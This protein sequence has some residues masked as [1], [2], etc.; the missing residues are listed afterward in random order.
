MKNKMIKHGIAII[1]IAIL[2]S[3]SVTNC[4]LLALAAQ[5]RENKEQARQVEETRRAE[6]ARQTE[7]IRQERLAQSQAQELSFGIEVSGY[8]GAGEAYWFKVQAVGDGQMSVRTSGNTSTYLEAYDSINNKITDS[9]RFASMDNNAGLSIF[10]EAGKNYFIRLR[11]GSSSISGQGPYSIIAILRQAQDLSSGT[12]VSGNL[13]ARETHWF[14]VQAT[15]NGVMVVYTS[16]NTDTFLRAYGSDAMEITSNN[17][18]GEGR[19]ARLRFPVIAGRTYF[20]ELF[21]TGGSS[22]TGGSY[23]IIALD[24]AIAADT[25]RSEEEAARRRLEEANRYDPSKFTLVPSNFR[26]ADYTARDLFNV[27][28]WVES[29]DFSTALPRVGNRQPFV[30]DVVFVRQDGTDI[31]FKTNDNAITQSMKINSRSGLTAGQS[32]R[33]YYMVT[34][35]QYRLAVW[36]V[37]AIERL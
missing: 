25:L 24:E 34:K 36:Q 1:G 26:P 6:E 28:A 15:G 18:G 20:I 19:N 13:G 33:L 37:I 9:G 16:G 17:D 29:F 5:E 32:V 8:L 23:R 21:G 22:S 2:V 11:G 4:V 7:A 30:S 10:V 31:W 14:T 12:D 27:V 3:L 35:E